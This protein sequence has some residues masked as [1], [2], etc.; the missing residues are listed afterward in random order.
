MTTTFLPFRPRRALAILGLSLLLHYLAVVWIGKRL[1]RVDADEVPEPPPATIIA[2]LRAPAQA[3]AP[4]QRAAP[5]ARPKTS[6]PAPAPGPSRPAPVPEAVP[7]VVPDAAPL[8]QPVELTAVP[9]VAAQEAKEGAQEGASHGAP[10]AAAAEAPA[11]QVSLPPSATLTLDVARRDAKG[12]DWSGQAVMDWQRDGANYR[13]RFVASV[14][15]L[16]TINL[17][18]LASEGTI[19]AEGIIPRTMTEKRRNRAQ[20][21][22]HFNAQD[23]RITFSA[24]QAIVSMSHGV[25]DKATFPIQLAGI[26]RAD[27]AQLAAGVDMLVGEDKGASVFHFALVGEEE[28]DT[29]MGRMKTWRLSR[30]PRPGSYNSRLDIWLAP[31]HH[32]YPVQ[33]RN[34]E[35]N[36]AV[37]T[38]TIRSIAIKGN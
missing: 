14:T 18:E 32:W 4:A 12:T 38:Q 20:T 33:I 29:G 30:P 10:P 6:R 3:P 27:P 1:G 34:T 37:T 5:A 19:G 22:T 36:G 35:A 13:L 15:V 26:A 23:Q 8:D 11:Y 28:I 24:S 21:A 17:A 25:Q 2:Q 7:P 9:E 31:L 16:V